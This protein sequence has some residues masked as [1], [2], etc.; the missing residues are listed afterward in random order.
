M[1]PGGIPLPYNHRALERVGE[2]LNPYNHRPQERF[3]GD[4]NTRFEIVPGTGDGESILIKVKPQDFDKFVAQSGVQFNP[5][6]PQR[7]DASNLQDNSVGVPSQNQFPSNLVASSAQFNV[8]P[9][10][11]PVPVKFTVPAN[12]QSNV[13]S[14]TRFNNPSSALFSD[15]SNTRF[16]VAPSTQNRN[17]SDTQFSINDPSSDQFPVQVNHPESRSNVQ[18]A[19]EAQARHSN[20]QSN[21]YSVLSSSG[22]EQRVRGQNHLL[23]KSVNQILRDTTAGNAQLI[24]TQPVLPS[25]AQRMPDNYTLI[26]PNVVDTFRCAGRVSLLVLPCLL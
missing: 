22:A 4:S 20:P 9:P 18:P 14:N 2:N 15:P 16:N 10:P 6:H 25:L 5:T 11:Q 3:G 17:P 13:A 23:Y 19:N 21:A 24:A 8:P 1:S 26:R 7:Y 12:P